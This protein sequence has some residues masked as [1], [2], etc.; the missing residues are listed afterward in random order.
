M[1][2]QTSAAITVLIRQ[3]SRGSSRDPRL[4]SRPPPVLRTDSPSVQGESFALRAFWIPASAGMTLQEN[5]SASTTG[6][7]RCAGVTPG[8]SR[9]ILSRNSTF[10]H[11]EKNRQLL[12]SSTVEH[13]QVL[14]ENNRAFVFFIP[15]TEDKRDFFLGPSAWFR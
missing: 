1:L 5:L 3:P 8:D 2:N 15:G 12:I 14:L 10:Q 7:L 11:K 4:H 9:A 6:N 13:L